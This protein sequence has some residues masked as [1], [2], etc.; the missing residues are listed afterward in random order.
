MP[1]VR[2][3]LVK[4]KTALSPPP[5]PAKASTP[6]PRLISELR[7][8][9][10]LTYHQHRVR[11]LQL[12]E[13]HLKHEPVQ[14]ARRAEVLPYFI[15]MVKSRI[16][17]SRPLPRER[18]QWLF[19]VSASLAARELFRLEYHQHCASVAWSPDDPS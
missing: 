3:R 13:A 15:A 11:K 8:L 2:P 12:F 5:T 18:K 14:W 7:I 10:T 17:R 4:R 16:V 19:S 6:K 9:G 1:D